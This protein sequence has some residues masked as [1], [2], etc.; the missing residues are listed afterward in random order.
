MIRD[1]G[2]KKKEKRGSIGE[3]MTPVRMAIF[4]N[5]QFFFLVSLE[6]KNKRMK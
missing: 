5:C 4:W 3:T 2:L 6:K 1:D